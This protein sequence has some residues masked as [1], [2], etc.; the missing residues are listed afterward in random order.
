[1]QKLIKSFYKSSLVTSAILLIIGILLLFKSTDTIIAISYIIGTI[2]IVIGIV[3]IFTFFKESSVKISND[4]NIVYG[5][6]SIILGALIISHPT[7]IATFIPYVIGVAILINSAI[8]LTYAMEAKNSGDDIWKSS[9]VM[10]A[11]SALCGI[12]IVF[13]PF[14]ASV[15]VF[16]IIGAF[17]V[18]YSILDI[19]YIVQVKHTFE[20]IH[21]V[22]AE[23]LKELTDSN[24]SVQMDAEIVEEKETKKDDEKPTKKSTKSNTKKRT[25]KKSTKKD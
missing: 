20:D 2:L 15:A 22:V 25:R 24:D 19:I 13:N 11:I 9:L 8:K 23:G 18:I 21:D 7:A 12:L 4:L 10:A 16:K 3:G 6:V 1:M 5:L 14:E 17:M